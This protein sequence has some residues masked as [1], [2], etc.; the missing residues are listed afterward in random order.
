MP[1]FLRERMAKKDF[2]NNHELLAVGTRYKK[3]FDQAKVHG[4]LPKN[5]NA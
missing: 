4:K 1:E 2:I 5:F 3:V